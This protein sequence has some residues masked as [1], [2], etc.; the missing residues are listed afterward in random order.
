MKKTDL[1][2]TSFT[3]KLAMAAIV[4]FTICGFI[5]TALAQTTL[6]STT[7]GTIANVNPTGW[8]F[9]G[10]AM[11]ISINNPGS[12]Y[13][14]FSGD[15]YLGE[16]NSVTFTNTAGNVQTSSPIGTSEAVLLLSTTNYSNVT[17]SF[18]MRRS[19]ASYSA[20]ATYTLAWSTDNI[21]YTDII[22]T[23]PAAG[24]WG[25]VSGS[26]LTLP[27]GASNQA[28]LYIRWKF[29]RTGTGSNIKIDDVTV[30]GGSTLPPAVISF[31]TNDTTVVETAGLANVIVRLT[32][33]S[34]FSSAISVTASP[35]SSASG[36]DY[37]LTIGTAT[38]AANAT[39]GSTAAITLSLTNDAALES[40]EYIIL[41]L[42][43]GQ[44]ANPGA[45][46]QFAFYIGDDDK[47]APQASNT[48]SL[49][50][51]SSFSNGASGVNSA[52]I[53]AHDPASQRLFI[54]NSI[55][56]KLD[57]INFV[58]PSS[59][60]LL[61]SVP[62]TTYGNI[63]SV[64]VKNGIVA[65]AIENTNPQD[66][67]SVVFFNINGVYQNKVKVGM[68]PD[69]ITFNHAGT[70]VL[71]AN[72][73]EPNAA[74]TNDP[75]GSISIVDISGGVSTLSQTNVAH[76]TFTVYNGQEATLRA[77]SIRIFGLNANAAK[78]FEPEYI[79][80]SPDD[81]KAWVGLQE[82]N[83][84]VEIN[85]STNSINYLKAL[86][87]KN[88][89][90]LNNGYDASNVTKGINI[91]NFPVKG[92]YMP[93]AIASYTVGGNAY[94]I[95]ANEG[96]SRSY[97]GFSEESR[98]SGLTLDPTKF[99]YGAELKNNYALGRLTV[100]NK[101]GDTDNDGD[102]DTIYSLGSRSFSIW[103]ASTGVQVY[104]SKDDLEQIT[105]A[106]SFSVL[107]NASNSNATRKD[108]SD[109]KGPEPEGVTIG[110]IGSN[111]YA[112]IALERVGGV[113]VYD[114]TNPAAPTF[115]RYVNNR[116]LPSNGPDLGAEGIIFIKQT[117][118]PN[119][120]HI[121]I[122]ANEVSSTLSIW[123]IPGCTSP[124]STSLSVAGATV[125][126]C[127]NSAP[128]LSVPASTAVT[129][130]WLK[131][132][133]PIASAT[134]NT[135][136]ANSTGNYA[137]A[138]TGGTN[139]AANSIIQSVTVNPTPTLT[140]S[141]PTAVC[142]G[143]SITQTVSG[144]LTYSFNSAASTSVITYTPSASGS[145]TLS[146]VGS[147][148]CSGTL[149]KQFVV[150]P[151]PA[152][153][154]YAIPETL[155]IG[156][157][158]TLTGTGA[159]S[160]S[161]STGA[162]GSAITLTPATTATYAVTGTNVYSC[163]TTLTKTV[164][165][166]PVPVITAS[167]S[168]TLVC[169]GENVVLT[170]VGGSSYQWNTGS[171]SSSISVNPMA[172]TVYTITGSNAQ[173]CSAKTVITQSVSEC[174]SLSEKNLNEVYTI[175][176]NPATTELSISFPGETTVGVKIINALGAVVMEE[177]NYTATSALNISKLSNGIYFVQITSGTKQS[178]KKIIVE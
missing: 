161:W 41:R 148:S 177:R 85:L 111:I 88:H 73:G 81:S 46:S 23:E 49:N 136:L 99:P 77:Q 134:S 58:N 159:N 70:K 171:T 153:N 155:C 170:A 45:T 33:T 2:K 131:N 152:L 127:A 156:E 129:Y 87:T 98:V 5:N 120:Q 60:V 15:A 107:F 52:E 61:Y 140:V 143:G 160:Y 105:A 157:T 175:Y 169:S 172:T 163:S 86:G 151:L 24:S 22:F 90:L 158:S 68:M 42:A 10:A 119:G 39:V 75:D 89:N 16:G 72:E 62:I 79:T 176:P 64:A 34:T 110:V 112:F 50:L 100:T 106:S 19:S 13:T 21:T 125:G 150:N 63:N 164:T 178:L 94:I 66:S 154:L 145:Y 65:C 118:S 11:N 36:A 121:V 55:G 51:L 101:N 1:T 135:I 56:G 53:V 32:T 113:M 83:A 104:D 35:L 29:D 130:Q 166:N 69:M 114:V 6:Y 26:G 67:G 18:G 84:L 142:L 117:D 27:A 54:A 44:N 102:I 149:V 93:D 128:V 132:G 124:L 7:F 173:N 92:F 146:G 82:N 137:V 80:V 133:T 78:D 48:L 57:I 103:D 123:G 97:S 9:T 38:F 91:A 109:D 43:N 96:D 71:T 167:S 116:S 147:N 139:C 115:V 174:T 126:A 3:S 144:A 108:R 138:I 95:S 20:N 122:A 168:S 4:F 47:T 31:V 17:L 74:Y 165:V 162:T 37:S 141:G 14:G 76:V 40:S 25:L 28:A 30:T 8:T 12:G 59:P